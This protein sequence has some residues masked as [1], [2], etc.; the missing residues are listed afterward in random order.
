MNLNR[1]LLAT[2]LSFG[3]AFVATA[4][5]PTP[6][7]TPAPTPT[8][9]P[10]DPVAPTEIPKN[11][12]QTVREAAQAQQD[13]RDATGKPITPPGQTVRTTAQLQGDFMQLDGDKNGSLSRTELNAEADLLTNFDTLDS[14][15]NGEISRT[16]FNASVNLAGTG[17]DGS[18]TDDEVEDE[19]EE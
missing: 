8:P 5:T 18:D 13:L 15:S 1:T 11:H 17:D 6:T 12:G 16:E 2:A 3:L 19:E 7:P 9:T 14:D 10:T 4:Q